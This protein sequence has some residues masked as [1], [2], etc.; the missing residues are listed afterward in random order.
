[1][2]HDHLGLLC[3]VAELSATLAG[4]TDIDSFLQKTVEVVACYTKSDVC[5]IYLYNRT[6]DLLVLRS[7]HGLPTEAVGE[8]KMPLGEGLVGTVM[9]ELKPLRVERGSSH[10]NWRYF[11]NVDQNRYDAFLAVPIRRGVE[12]LGVLVVQRASTHAYTETDSKALEATALQ[13]ASAI[14]N[15]RMI[16]AARQDNRDLTLPA[17]ALQIVK[18]DVASPGFAI[19]NVAVLNRQ[20]SS[21][22]PR[23]MGEDE[24]YTLDDFERALQET[25]EQLQALQD[26]LAERLPEVAELIFS[27]HLL[28][29]HDPAFVDRVRALIN[30]Q[31]MNPPEAVYQVAKKYLDLFAASKNAYTRERALDVEDLGRRLIGNIR[32]QLNEPHTNCGQRILLAD[33]LFPSDIMKLASE[34]ASGIAL[35]SGGVTSHVSIL[36]RSLQIPLI[37]ADEPRL[38]N[39]ESD[40]FLVLDG[41]SGNIYINPDDE[42]YAPLRNRLDTQIVSDEKKAGMRPETRTSDGTRVRLLA[43]IN[44]LSDL[45]LARDLQAEGVGLYRSEFPFL[46]RSD[47]PTEDEQYPI[48]RNLIDG[49]PGQE[50]TFRTLDIGGDK[51]MACF[52]DNQQEA[53]P[54]L[55]MRSIRFLL[56]HL[57]IFHDQVRAF[58][59][60]ASHAG[61]R[62]IRLMFPMVSSLDEFIQARQVID[63]CRQE[64]TEDGH[65]KL[66]E[67][68]LGIMVEVPSIV[69]LLDD[70]APH[71]DFFCIGTNDLIQYLL[72][73]DRTNEKVAPYF[74]PFHPAVLRSLKRIA[75]ASQRHEVDVSICGEMA[76]ESQYIPFLIGIGIRTLSLDPRYLP[77]VQSCVQSL[78]IEDAEEQARQMLA[79]QTVDDMREYFAEYNA[80]AEECADDSP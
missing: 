72:A 21:M 58:L 32:N 10:P 31:G 16:T 15:V 44:L 4:S 77:D 17:Q 7:T 39:L 47:F 36:A 3:E 18:G 13:L 33:T 41:Y 63:H 28:I 23:D 73:V 20:G 53:N 48:Y 55:G 6:K 49:M 59:R 75:E 2:P 74:L 67:I 37:I 52:D 40:T 57:Q 70:I 22:M 11:S 60:A 1:M 76:H 71:V 19:G 42:V 9:R 8:V 51:V 30:E 56:R 27:A 66:P 79:I 12:R 14:E 78:T 80:R 61:D 45:V 43:N 69:E 38:L 26:E 50:L 5:S 34:E 29:L 25:E 24:T 65:D 62:H 54:N 68:S 46:I 64:L 35:T